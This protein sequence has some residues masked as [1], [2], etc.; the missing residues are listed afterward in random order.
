M[1]DFNL[2]LINYQTHNHTGQFLDDMYSYMFFPL[3]T[4][5]SRITSHT[6]TLIDNI[7][8]N[9]LDGNLR[10]GLLFTDISDHLPIF[11]IN[12]TTPSQHTSSTDNIQVRANSSKNTSNFIQQLKAI[13]WSFLSDSFND[14]NNSYDRFIQVFSDT[15]DR[16]CP[17]KTVK[18]KRYLSH[19]P[20]L[21]KGIL[22]S[23]RS[24]NKLYKKYLK[25]PSTDNETAY[26]T[27]KN[28]L[29]VYFY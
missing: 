3:I 23:I 17:L 26:K 8:C 6:A 5:P 22:K 7:F 4:R 29:N 2:N 27:Y 24:K 18:K 1:G 21:S 19:K 15:Y 25:N 13:D 10:N 9:F 14:P 20:W 11:T 28:K 16:C 12:F